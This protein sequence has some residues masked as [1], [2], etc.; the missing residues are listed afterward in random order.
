MLFLLLFS[1]VICI[2]CAYFLIF[3]SLAFNKSKKLASQSVQ[4]PISVLVY[5]KDNAALLEENLQAILEQ[6]HSNFELILINHAS[7]DKSLEFIEAFQKQHPHFPIHICDVQEN[8][9]FWDSKKYALFL[10]LK[11][12]SYSHF[13]LTDATC[14]PSSKQ[15]IDE[16]CEGF[17]DEKQIVLGYSTYHRRKGLFN[18]LL[19]FDS[20][21]NTITS[22]SFAHAK[23]TYM[24]IGRNLAFSKKAYEENYGFISHVKIRSGEEDLFIHEVATKKNSSLAWSKAAHIETEPLENIQAWSSQFKQKAQSFKYYKSKHKV[25]LGVYFLSRL[26]FWIGAAAAFYF[27]TWQLATS[28]IAIRFFF[29]YLCIG[30]VAN[31]LHASKLIL[32]LPFLEIP[33]LFLQLSNATYFIKRPIK[34][35]FAQ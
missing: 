22:L 15:W 7:S 32:F 5:I 34:R 19:R 23:V 18:L 8:E 28:L 33:L 14:K 2:N 35:R 21:L 1:I 12:A 29:Q 27:L 30:I 11:K 9:S 4:L 31:K 24:G 16:M 6:D 3:L 25:V 13:L 26:L 17:H 10:G 20:L